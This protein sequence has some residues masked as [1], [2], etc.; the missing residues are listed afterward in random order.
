MIP[1]N[2]AELIDGIVLLKSR[3]NTHE[4]TMNIYLNSTFSYINRRIILWMMYNRLYKY[5]N[6]N[7]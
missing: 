3:I 2:I 7:K 1:V 4:V 5:V 6:Y